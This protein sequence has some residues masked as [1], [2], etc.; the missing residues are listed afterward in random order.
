MTMELGGRVTIECEKN[1]LQAELEFKLKVAQA[2]QPP[3]GLGGCG[4]RAGERRGLGG[5][6]HH[7]LCAQGWFF[8][9]G[10]TGEQ[11]LA[12]RSTAGPCEGCREGK[13]LPADHTAEPGEAEARPHHGAPRSVRDPAPWS[14]GWAT[15]KCGRPFCAPGLGARTPTRKGP[16]LLPSS[17]PSPA[18]ISG[19]SP[20]PFFGGSTS[21]NQISGKITSGEEVLARLTG[22][23]RHENGTPC[24]S[25][26]HSVQLP[27]CV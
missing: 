4:A 23:W 12:F 17:A 15:G 21:I 13:G 27:S 1:S 5:F 14:S 26:S 19:M 3:Q 11:F 10:H 24:N 16:L 22:K 9:Q 18:S 25:K 6:P 20:Q 7:P 8:E 2:A